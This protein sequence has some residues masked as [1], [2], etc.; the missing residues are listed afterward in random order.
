MEVLYIPQLDEVDASGETTATRC[1]LL[2]KRPES[3]VVGLEDKAVNKIAITTEDALRLV[4]PPL[5]KGQ[6]RDFFVRLVIT[7]DAIPEVTFAAPTGEIIS[8]EDIDDTV[9]S[10]Q[11]GINVFSFT[12]NDEGVF[13]VNRKVMD[14]DY[15][16]ELDACGGEGVTSPKVFKLG[17]KF[18]GLPTPIR[19]G[20]VFQGWFTAA[21]GGTQVTA[22]DTVKTGIT[23][24]YAQW[25]VYV[26]PFVD[27]ICE[28]K[29]LTF[30]TSGNGD[31]YVDAATYHSE[32]GAARSGGISDSQNTILQTSFTGA[33]T[34]SFWWKV[35]SEDY[36]DKLRVILDGTEKSYISGTWGDWEQYT[37]EVTGDGLH[38][39]QWKYDKDG[40][41]SN[42]EDCGWVDDV[43]WTPA[44]A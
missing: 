3:G 27:A 34:L 39:V 29:N 37:L 9:L 33:G 10:C 44:G 24:L 22:N 20:Y 4:L 43:V 38:T 5:V 13:F 41:C 1:K 12:E 26:D 8:F 21:E 6:V 16:I 35:S 11:I 28:A 15:S 32:P 40:S 42:G 2:T 30:Y 7:S 19:N 14:I 17:A 25:T 23:K 36:Y 18:T 31:W